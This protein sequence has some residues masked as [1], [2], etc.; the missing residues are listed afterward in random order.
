MGVSGEQTLSVLL[1]YSDAL[2]TVPR[3]RGEI[4]SNAL[5]NLRQKMTPLSSAW[6]E[7]WQGLGAE[8]SIRGTCSGQ[9]FRK[10]K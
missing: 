7:Y 1:E 5:N 2:F 6:R 9:R 10:P 3:P 8:F 4:A